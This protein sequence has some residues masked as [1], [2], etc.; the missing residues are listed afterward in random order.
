MLLFMMATISVSAN[1][2]E[3]DSSED[4]VY[5]VVECMPTFPGGSEALF[6]FLSDNI[7]YPA[8]ALR[9]DK[10]GRVMVSFVIGGNGN[11]SG[12]NVVKKVY[13]SL[14]DEAVRLIK[15]MPKWTPGTQAGKVVKVKILFQ[16]CSG[17]LNIHQKRTRR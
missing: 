9:K 13:P 15:K 2:L 3:G 4:K 14:D 16:L 17:C 8:D 5:E 1:S 11:V 7:K 10:R 6:L 12:L